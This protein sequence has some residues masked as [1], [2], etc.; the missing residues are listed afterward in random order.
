MRGH[1]EAD[2]D[3]LGIE[4]RTDHPELDYRTYGFSEA[5]LD[6]EIFI[7][8]LL[9]RERATLREI[10]GLLREIYCGCIGVEYMHIQELAERQWIQQRIRAPRCQAEPDHTRR[11][12]RCCGF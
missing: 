3:P 2:L 11:K 4:R 8:N 6:R 12:K 7:N 9:G 5:D 1:L 10:V